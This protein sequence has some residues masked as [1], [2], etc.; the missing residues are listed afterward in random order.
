MKSPMT[1]VEVLD[2]VFTYLP[3]REV[4]LLRDMPLNEPLTYVRV[5]GAVREHRIAL[6][7]DVSQDLLACLGDVLAPDP[8]R[9]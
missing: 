3:E 6:P 4:A 1:R 5:C 8:E 7:R 2:A 9:S